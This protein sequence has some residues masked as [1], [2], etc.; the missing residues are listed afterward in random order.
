MTLT[1]EQALVEYKHLPKLCD[2][3]SAMAL[4]LK[5]DVEVILIYVSMCILKMKSLASVVRKVKAEQ[6]HRQ[7]RLKFTYL[8]RMV[9]N[10]MCIYL[11]VKKKKDESFITHNK[12][13]HFCGKLHQLNDQIRRCWGNVNLADAVQAH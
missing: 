13:S 1:I 3:C 10:M 2:L 9:I 6:T 7:I 8:W 4:I 11:L 12:F 5:N